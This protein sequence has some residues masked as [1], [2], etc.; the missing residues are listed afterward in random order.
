[1]RNLLILITL[2]FFFLVSSEEIIRKLND[3][4]CI[5]L[6]PCKKDQIGQICGNSNCKYICKYSITGLAFPICS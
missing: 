6:S 5:H 2:I 4:Q 1:M 3:L